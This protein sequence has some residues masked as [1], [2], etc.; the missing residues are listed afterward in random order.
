MIKDKGLTGKVIQE[1]EWIKIY[2]SEQKPKTF[3]FNIHS[4]SSNRELGKIRWYPPWRKYI[5]EPTIGYSI[6]LSDR[7]QFAIA[8]FTMWINAQHIMKYKN[9]LE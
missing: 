3:V 6:T 1:D 4:K 7:C 9:L 2:V 8:G 5:F